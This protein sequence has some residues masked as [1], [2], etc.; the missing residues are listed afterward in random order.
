MA[1]QDNAYYTYGEAKMSILSGILTGVSITSDNLATIAADRLA[2]L[3]KAQ[4][5]R[6]RNARPILKPGTFL[7][8]PS[9][10]EG[11]IDGVRAVAVMNE[12]Q[13]PVKYNFSE[14][15]LPEEC[16]DLLEDKTYTHEIELAPHDA[17]LLR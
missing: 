11:T 5:L 17:I 10:F 9:V 14:L 1:R 2:L 13:S 15:G 7:E 12:T 8:W 6:M 16:T 4:N 3:G